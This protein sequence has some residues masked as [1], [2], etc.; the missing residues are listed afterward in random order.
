MS[1]L[2]D[3]DWEA[4]RKMF[5]P[6]KAFDSLEPAIPISQDRLVYGGC[7]MSADDVHFLFVVDCGGMSD[8]EARALLASL[9]S[10][11]LRTVLI[12][13]KKLPKACKPWLDREHPGVSSTLVD[14]RVPCYFFSVEQYYAN[15]TSSCHA[16]R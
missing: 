14:I 15:E 8:D 13:S 11:P 1:A 4:L 10:D 3:T 6:Q 2:D 9:N 12:G 7:H 16:V 5:F